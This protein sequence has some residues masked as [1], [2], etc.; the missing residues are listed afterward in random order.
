MDAVR[1]EQVT[2]GY[3]LNNPSTEDISVAIDVND[4]GLVGGTDALS[5]DAIDIRALLWRDRTDVQGKL[6]V[7][8]QWCDVDPNI[9]PGTDTDIGCDSDIG[10]GNGSLDRGDFEYL[11]PHIIGTSWLQETR[12]R[13]SA[14]GD[15]DVVLYRDPEPLPLYYGDGTAH[16]ALDIPA[17]ESRILWI[18]IDVPED[19]TT[20][21]YLGTSGGGSPIELTATG[22]TTSEVVEI[23][24]DIRVPC[25]DLFE[26]R[27][28]GFALW[29][30]SYS[31]G[32]TAPEASAGISNGSLSDERARIRRMAGTNT[33][34]TYIGAP[35]RIPYTNPSVTQAWTW[36][37]GGLAT[38]IRRLEGLQWNDPLPPFA[39]R[40][41]KRIVVAVTNNEAMFGTDW[42]TDP[43][44]PS[45]LWETR[46]ADLWIDFEAGM[47]SRDLSVTDYEI[48]VIPVDEPTSVVGYSVQLTG[49]NAACYGNQ[50]WHDSCDSVPECWHQH[51][52][53]IGSTPVTRKTFFQHAAR[54]IRATE[55]TL[56]MK[57]Q[58][59]V[60]HNVLKRTWCDELQIDFEEC[61]GAGSDCVDIW[62]HAG[63]MSDQPDQPHPFNDGNTTPW[64]DLDD[65]FWWYQ[66][67]TADGS[68]EGAMRMAQSGLLLDDIGY[69]G[70]GNWTFWAADADPGFRPTPLIDPAHRTYNLH[71]WVTTVPRFWNKDNSVYFA[72]N[73]TP[74]GIPNADASAPFDV[75][76]GEGLIPGRTILARRQALEHFTMLRRTLDGVSGPTQSAFLTSAAA[77]AL[78]ALLLEATDPCHDAGDCLLGEASPDD[79]SR[80]MHSWLSDGHDRTGVCSSPQPAYYQGNAD[81]EDALNLSPWSL[82]TNPPGGGQ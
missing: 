75:P 47:D 2:L 27:A 32:R 11:F 18:T 20:G 46:Y 35:S 21:R 28:D 38:D 39:D 31:P 24:L 19:Q 80:V 22:P 5:A 41:V 43:D 30:Y 78:Q 8:E 9:D 14:A 56:N 15:G 57:P 37:F 25:W 33:A 34:F 79:I 40:K 51:T 76:T 6:E 72:P 67:D 3:W 73:Y 70:F 17:G 63:M 7:G 66:F 53:L 82:T 45:A 60:N 64:P 36:T 52:I 48:V 68:D 77:S 59:L 44:Q 29:D 54:V 42:G 61:D 55:P 26:D 58:I 23:E 12:D 65:H 10:I 62:M 50:G 1:G 16:S 81:V 69:E 4:M 49:G 71:S 74:P 13:D